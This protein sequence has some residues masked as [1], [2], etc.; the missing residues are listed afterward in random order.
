[1]GMAG[2]T[3]KSGRRVSLLDAGQL[4]RAARL[5]AMGM[6]WRETGAAIGVTIYSVRAALE[7]GFI[8]KKREYSQAYKRQR[9]PASS[10]VVESVSAPQFVLFEREQAMLAPR[11]LTAV[12]C[13]DPPAGRSALDKRGA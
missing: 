10:L 11:S 2:K 4:E 9:Y 13:G 6:G 8:D 12:L 3:G 1:M 5:R 7:P